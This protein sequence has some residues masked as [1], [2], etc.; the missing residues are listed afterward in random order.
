MSVALD[1]LPLIAQYPFW[2]E[3]AK[4]ATDA[5]SI[6]SASFAKAVGIFADCGVVNDVLIAAIIADAIR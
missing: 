6:V 2:R 4:L 3:C 1:A 5:W